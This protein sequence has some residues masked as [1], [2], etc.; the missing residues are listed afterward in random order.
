[1]QLDPLAVYEQVALASALTVETALRRTLQQEAQTDSVGRQRSPGQ[2][3]KVVFAVVEATGIGLRLEQPAAKTP[4]AELGV[5]Q[6]AALQ[7]LG[8]LVR[9]VGVVRKKRIATRPGGAAR[10]KRLDQK[11]KRGA[12]KALRRKVTERE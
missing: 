4:A 8:H 1:M 2:N 7:R 9:S 12:A 3:R 6:R 5:L 10:A 11:T